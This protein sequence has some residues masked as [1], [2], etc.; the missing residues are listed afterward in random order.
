[1]NHNNKCIYIILYIGINVIMHLV[2]NMFIVFS[3]LQVQQYCINCGICM[4][5]YFC[6]TCKFFDDDVSYRKL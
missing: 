3:T 5:E 1:M 6:G 4:G 2:A